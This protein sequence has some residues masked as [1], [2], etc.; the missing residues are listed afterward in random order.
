MSLNKKSLGISRTNLGLNNVANLSPSEL[1][2]LFG[3]FSNQPRYYVSNNGNGSGSDILH[4]FGVQEFINF[5]ASINIPSTIYLLDDINLNA[6]QTSILLTKINNLEIIGYRDSSNSNLIYEDW[7]KFLPEEILGNLVSGVTL[8]MDFNNQS[9]DFTVISLTNIKLNLINASS[10]SFSVFAYKIAYCISE[11]VYFIDLNYDIVGHHSGV[12]INSIVTKIPKMHIGYFILNGSS[13]SYSVPSNSNITNFG[14]INGVFSFEDNPNY[15]I[16]DYNTNTIFDKNNLTIISDYPIQ[17]NYETLLSWSQN[18]RLVPNQCYVL[19]D[20]LVADIN[21]FNLE[22]LWPNLIP[23]SLVLNSI[24][25]S[26]FSK[27]VSSIKHPKDIIEYILN[28]PGNYSNVG[29]YRGIITYR[30]DE[31]GNEAEF[32]FRNWLVKISTP[33]L[34]LLPTWDSSIVYDNTQSK[35]VIKDGIGYYRVTSIIQGKV[36]GVSHEWIPIPDNFVGLE[37]HPANTSSDNYVPGILGDPIEMINNESTGCKIK[38]I[39]KIFGNYTQLVFPN[40]IIQG[41]NIELSY[42]GYNYIDSALV[43]KLNLS[44]NNVIYNSSD[45][46]LDSN[47]EYINVV[48]SNFIDLGSKAEYVYVGNSRRVR[49]GYECENLLL[50]GSNEVNI[51]NRISD[52]ILINCLCVDIKD[53]CSKITLIAGDPYTLNN[54]SIGHNCETIFI[55]VTGSNIKIGSSCRIIILA[56]DYTEPYS[57]GP[58]KLWSANNLYIGSGSSSIALP[59]NVLN[60]RI[61]D[62]V[63]LFN[64][65]RGKAG[66]SGEYFIC[67]ISN[68]TVYPGASNFGVQFQQ[69]TQDE[70]TLLGNLVIHKIFGGTPVSPMFNVPTNYPYNKYQTDIYFD[71]ESDTYRI[72]PFNLS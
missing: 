18:E 6:N 53:N 72:D 8:T 44:N 29:N 31:N 36:P 3:G 70:P 68:I 58:Q 41:V 22:P 49:L 28:P 34:S 19:T 64:I 65:Y 51:L 25:K 33:D 48:D 67:D 5:V 54:V 27:R 13:Y 45:I 47:S 46:I 40:C 11:N 1:A 24:S 9:S 39:F 2:L 26:E 15:V 66:L 56:S 42:S 23:E 59:F 63:T 62:G 32:D 14:I 4:P 17:S 16:R 50:H 60:I 35:A 38:N 7:M 37:F 43:V 10:D 55:P 52:S 12:I 21:N 30:M 71:S 57:P 20:Y 61:L 69:L